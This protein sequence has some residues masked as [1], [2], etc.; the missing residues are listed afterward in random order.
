M[1]ASSKIAAGSGFSGFAG[2]Q[3]GFPRDT[4]IDPE[5]PR[6]RLSPKAS[7]ILNR[8][9]ALQIVRTIS[10]AIFRPYLVLMF[11]LSLLTHFALAEGTRT[12]EQSRF[13]DLV[14]GT[15]N[16]VAVRSSGGLELAPSFKLLY[17]TP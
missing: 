10:R 1:R 15:A 4:L 11:S 13:E 14:K 9:I 6:D 5:F 7:R 16:G 2:A 3:R 8:G 12:W 17:S